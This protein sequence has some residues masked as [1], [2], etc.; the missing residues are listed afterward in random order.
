MSSITSKLIRNAPGT[1]GV[2]AA[3]GSGPANATSPASA[4]DTAPGRVYQFK[5]IQIME[6]MC[7][8]SVFPLSSGIKIQGVFNHV[9]Q[10]D[11][12]AIWN[13]MSYSVYLILSQPLQIKLHTL[14]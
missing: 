8:L 10:S 13:L 6:H 11:R 1:E 3:E 12:F 2:A 7:S 9:L 4:T 5:E 14:L